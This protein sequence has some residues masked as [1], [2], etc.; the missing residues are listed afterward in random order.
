MLLIPDIE[1]GKNACICIVSYRHKNKTRS[2]TDLISS[3][4]NR[5]AAPYSSLRFQ[6][7]QHL[8]ASCHRRE[9]SKAER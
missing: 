5:V 8:S 9:K 2:Q 7:S 3:G 6:L 1:G 4:E